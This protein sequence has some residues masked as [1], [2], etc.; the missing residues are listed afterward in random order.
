MQ[1]N[2]KNQIIGVALLIILIGGGYL[3]MRGT[4]PFSNAPEGTNMATS[5]ALSAT[6]TQLDIA[7][8]T[9]SVTATGGYIVQEVPPEVSALEAPDHNAPIVFSAS[10]SLSADQ[11]SAI[12]KQAVAMRAQLAK[13][14]SNYSAWLALGGFFLSAGD[15]AQAAKI[16]DYVS[17]NWPADA[18]VLGNLGDLYMTYLKDYPKAEAS[19][20]GAIRNDPYQK[21][22]YRNL[23]TLYSIA[24][25]PRNSAAEDILKEGIK[26]NPD[27]LDFYVSLARYYRDTGRTGE[28]RTAYDAAITQAKRPVNAG[29]VGAASDLEAEQAALK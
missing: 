15:Y 26:N 2:T 9:I 12:E 3:F 22:A 4:T 11:K 19:Y 13:D 5:T 24:Y 25:T 28:A 20:L 8:G 14:I 29:A 21:N 27:T 10:S 23:F 17:L 16:W 6:T 18:T 7:G 1:E